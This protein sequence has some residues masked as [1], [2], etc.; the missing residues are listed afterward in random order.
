MCVRCKIGIVQ[1]PVYK[2]NCAECK[3]GPQVSLNLVCMCVFF[4]PLD[5]GSLTFS[6]RDPHVEVLLAQ[7]PPNILCRKISDAFSLPCQR[8]HNFT[9]LTTL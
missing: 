7:D 6:C 9:T 3:I 4:L 2:V 5:R 8:N 1:A